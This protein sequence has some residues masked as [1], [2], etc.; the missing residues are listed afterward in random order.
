MNLNQVTLGTTNIAQTKVFYQLL[1]FILIVDT[2]HYLR[3]ACPV[4][5]ASFSFVLEQQVSSTTTVYFEHEALDNAVDALLE[6]G[7][8][9]IELPADKPYLWREAVLSDPSG[10]KIKLFWAG[11]NRLNPPWKVP[12]KAI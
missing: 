10:N 12:V 4:G 9:F 3:F 1:G 6:K 11:K 5:E 8:E 2:P 7:V